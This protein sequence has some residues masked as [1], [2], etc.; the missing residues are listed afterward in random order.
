MAIGK[1][2]LR[3]YKKEMTQSHTKKNSPRKSK[4]TTKITIRKEQPVEEKKLWLT[5]EEYL[6]DAKKNP[7]VYRGNKKYQALFACTDY[8]LRN[9]EDQKRFLQDIQDGLFVFI[10]KEGGITFE[11]V[12][13]H[14]VID[15][16]YP[17]MGIIQGIEKFL[18][19]RIRAKFAEINLDWL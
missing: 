11:P 4:K 5:I 1:T 2:S 14:D 9:K 8:S 16:Q 13:L 7:A 17:V 10:T 6:E 18:M 3:S 19:F 15:Y 12:F